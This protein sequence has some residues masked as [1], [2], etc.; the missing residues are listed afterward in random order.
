MV[1]LPLVHEPDHVGAD[2]E[3][4]A[5]DWWASWGVIGERAQDTPKALA[6]DFGAGIVG[7]TEEEESA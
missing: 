2:A 4:D 7:V 6:F 1:C 5:D 3:D